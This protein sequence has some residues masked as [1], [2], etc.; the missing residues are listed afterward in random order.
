MDPSAIVFYVICGIAILVWYIKSLKKKNEEA[1]RRGEERS[2]DVKAFEKRKMLYHQFGNYVEDLFSDADQYTY[3]ELDRICRRDFPHYRSAT[4]FERNTLFS[5]LCRADLVDLDLKTKRYIKGSAFTDLRLNFTNF[6][7]FLKHDCFG[8]S[9]KET[10]FIDDRFEDEME[11]QRV[12][13]VM[14]NGKKSWS[15]RKTMRFSL[16]KGKE[17]IFFKKEITDGYDDDQIYLYCIFEV[18][19]EDYYRIKN[20]LLVLSQPINDDWTISEYERLFARV[21]TQFENYNP[22]A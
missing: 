11:T 6:Q 22:A 20:Q 1:E 15:D 8:R 9:Y 19:G 3:E 18:R 2:V 7:A 13:P 14:V 21:Q 10:G 16:V 17:I 4:D 12:M 5:D